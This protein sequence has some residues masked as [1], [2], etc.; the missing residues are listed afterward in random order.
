MSTTAVNAASSAT[1]L[2]ASGV[3]Q[4]VSSPIAWAVGQ[5]SD[6]ALIGG[7]ACCHVYK[8]VRSIYDGYTEKNKL[9]E[10]SRSNTTDTLEKLQ[11]RIVQISANING[12]EGKVTTAAGALSKAVQQNTTKL[13]NPSPEAL[14]AEKGY[15]EA[16]KNL[17]AAQEELA[18]LKDTLETLQTLPERLPGLLKE[19]RNKTIDGGLYLGCGAVGFGT[20]A[21]E[22]TVGK[23]ITFAGGRLI[24]NVAALTIPQA[25]GAAAA[26]VALP[27]VANQSLEKGY[28]WVQEGF[29]SKSKKHMLAGGA[30][31]VVGAT[32]T[33]GISAAAATVATAAG[34][35][36]G[37][38]YLAGAAAGLVTTHGTQAVTWV[39]KKAIGGLATAGGMLLKA[40]VS[41]IRCFTG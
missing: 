36:V 19:A 21:L 35:S 16:V 25:T 17:S 3:Y 18:H 9:L 13:E 11:Q 22:G 20:V 41:L 4:A 29:K 24:G 14:K 32:L 15:L 5:A 37:T 30:A 40:P 38:A 28:Q 23:V 1:Q 33:V 6:A 2:A 31:L 34:A 27:I 7:T 12:L 26:V 8:G 10:L 39:G